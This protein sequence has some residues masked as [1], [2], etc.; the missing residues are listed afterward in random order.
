M[1]QR[2]ALVS[3]VIFVFILVVTVILFYAYY[4]FVENGGAYNINDTFVIGNWNLEIFGDKKASDPS[5]MNE[6]SDVINHYDIIFLQEIRDQDA[7]SFIKLCGMLPDYECNISSRAGRSSSKEQYGIV[8]LKKFTLNRIIDYNF[9]M[10]GVW[11][12]PPIRADFSIGNYSFTV[13]N[14]HTKPNETVKELRSL[15]TL[16]DSEGTQGNVLVLGDLNADCSYYDPYYE[17]VFST[18]NWIIKSTDDTTTGASDCAYDRILLN[19][20]M[21]SEFV[22]YGIYQDNI[23]EQVSDHYPVWVRLRDQDYSRDT[24]FHTFVDTMI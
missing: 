6:Y 8:Y 18:W 17:N 4:E 13:Y 23:G 5:L 16:V 24:S 1:K 10:S 2:T 3:L 22:D 12:R 20:N 15:E 19:S 21:Y 11:E 7:S 14:I 9:N